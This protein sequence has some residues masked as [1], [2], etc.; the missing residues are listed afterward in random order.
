MF[1][2]YDD[3]GDDAHGFDILVALKDGDSYSAHSGCM[4][5]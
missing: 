3:D 5:E 4:P 1:P 2:P